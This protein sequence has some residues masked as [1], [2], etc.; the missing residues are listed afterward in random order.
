MNLE[1]RQDA[2]SV[3]EMLRST[4][5]ERCYPLSRH[6]RNIPTN[7][8][9]YAFRHL[10]EIL[11]IGITNNL[12]YRFSKGHKALGWA[13]LERLDPDDVRIAVVKLGSRTPEQ[14][15]YIETLMIQ[16][17]QPRYNVMKK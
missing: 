1:L 8:G 15:S 17:A 12:R 2:Q 13:F 10:D 11:Y 9:F 5:F 3:L 14:G 7:P 16:S 6:F 4:E